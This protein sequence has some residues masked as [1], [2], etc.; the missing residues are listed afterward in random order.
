[1]ARN[2]SHKGSLNTYTDSPHLVLAIKSQ[3]VIN[4]DPFQVNYCEQSCIEIHSLGDDYPE[5]IT[6]DIQTQIQEDQT[7][8]LHEQIVLLQSLCKKLI[9]RWSCLRMKWRDS[10]PW[11]RY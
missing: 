4:L 5:S 2:Q 6:Y 3:C 7:T 8:Q 11:S 1:L 10:G 9:R